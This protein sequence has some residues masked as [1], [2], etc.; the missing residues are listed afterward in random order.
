MPLTTARP[1]LWRRR[2]FVPNYQVGEAARYAD[3][4]PKTVLAWQKDASGQTI[5][6]RE[7]RS[8]L[9]Y[10]QLIEVAV[11]A[12]FRKSGV[13]LREIKVSRE[14]LSKRLEAEHPFAEYSFKTD[15]KSLFMDYEQVAGKKGTGTLLRPGKG[16]QLAW[17]EII[18]RL[19]EFEYERKGIVIKWHVDGRDSPIVI[20]PRVAFGAPT[21]NGTPTWVLKGRWEAGEAVDEIVDDFGLRRPE[22]IEAL[23]FEGIDASS[24][25]ESA[26]TH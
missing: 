25:R 2:L 3:I 12:A 11:V 15:G 20:D 7:K 24:R 23:R 5:S 18:G 1:E 13:S 16:G 14:Y 9:S 10:L 26:W 6:S 8:P 4:S 22:V 21:I 17:D 19:N